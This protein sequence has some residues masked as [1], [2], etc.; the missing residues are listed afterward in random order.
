MTRPLTD[1]LKANLIRLVG[2]EPVN[3]LEIYSKDI[4]TSVIRVT[5]HL[6]EIV[7]NGQ[8]YV[9]YPFSLTISNDQSSQSAT[10]NL[11]L[12]N[13][14]RAL[15]RWLEQLQGAPHAKLRHMKIQIADPDTI[16]IDYLYDLKSIT[17]T[18]QTI[19]GRLGYDEIINK[20]GNPTTYRPINAP[21]LF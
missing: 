16:E 7:S 3:L 20:I 17:V 10:A 21:G 4:P 12:D 2:E 15:P 11:S 5:D 18:R 19:S 14:S 1:N 13:V 8:T 9:P 6:R